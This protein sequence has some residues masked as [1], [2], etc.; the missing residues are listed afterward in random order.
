MRQLGGLEMLKKSV[1]LYKLVLW[2]TT[3]SGESE[4]TLNLSKINRLTPTYV[5]GLD[6]AGKL[7]EIRTLEPFNYHLQQIK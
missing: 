7:I 6:P 2:Y 4:K 5:K 1:S 3:P